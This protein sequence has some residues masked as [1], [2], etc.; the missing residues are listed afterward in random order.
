MTLSRLI[1]LKMRNISAKVCRENQ[2]TNFMLKSISENPA[3]YYLYIMPKYLVEPERPQMAILRGVAW[4]NSKT[5]R[6]KLIAF[7]GQ[8][9][10]RERASMLCYTYIAS[11]VLYL[12]K[13][14]M[15]S[16]Y[17]T[18]ALKYTCLNLI[19]KCKKKNIFVFLLLNSQ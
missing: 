18:P 4:W 9:R 19:K 14:F 15:S 3:V 7:P 12:N 16:A 8:K 11:F 17:V 6:A 1:N 2:N 10:F 13:S 5:A